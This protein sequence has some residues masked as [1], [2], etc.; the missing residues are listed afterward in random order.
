[1]R[2]GHPAT[3]WLIRKP[4]TA[5]VLDALKQY[6]LSAGHY[7]TY[8]RGLRCD[9]ALAVLDRPEDRETLRYDAQ[10]LIDHC[11]GGAYSYSYEHRA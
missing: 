9:G 10:W 4:E 7:Q 3:A 2:S 1:M 5:R 11:D 8:C 6:N